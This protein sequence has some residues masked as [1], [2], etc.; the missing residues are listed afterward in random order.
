MTWLTRIG[1][2]CLCVAI[3]LGILAIA[4]VGMASAN[5]HS[6]PRINPQT[7]G[8]FL[9]AVSCFIFLARLWSVDADAIPL[10]PRVAGS[11]ALLPL[12]AWCLWTT[13]FLAFFV[14]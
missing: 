14:G 4:G 13:Y 9:F 10:G 7:L 1:V 6:T 2:A 8:L 3:A 11:L 12:G 5:A